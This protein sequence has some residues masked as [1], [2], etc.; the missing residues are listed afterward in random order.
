MYLP[1]PEDVPPGA[2][3]AAEVPYLF[4]D[5][6][7]EAASTPEQRRLSDLMIGYWTNFA[8][9]GDPNSDALP[10][11]SRFDRAESRPVVQ[12]LSTGADG[13]QPVDYAAEHHLD[14]WVGLP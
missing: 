10:H 13:I 7:F 4:N 14:L 9:T 6:K 8:H 3:H 11:W 5:E 2:F 12:S 1:F